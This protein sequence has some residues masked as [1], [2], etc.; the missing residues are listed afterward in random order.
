VG[1]DLV[2]RQRHPMYREAGPATSVRWRHDLH[3]AASGV[4]DTPERAAAER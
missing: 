4:A 2:R 1:R 3:F